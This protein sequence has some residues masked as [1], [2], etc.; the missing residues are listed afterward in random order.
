MKRSIV[1]FVSKPDFAGRRCSSNQERYVKASLTSDNSYYLPITF[2]VEQSTDIDRTVQAVHRVVLAE[3][4]LNVT[5]RAAGGHFVCAAPSSSPVACQIESGPVDA[6]GLAERIAAFVY[7]PQNILGAPTC[8]LH[9]ARLDEPE[10]RTAITIALHHAVADAISLGL[11]A[12]RVSQACAGL[13]AAAPAGRDYF[14]LCDHYGLMPG[15][16]HPADVHYWAGALRTAPDDCGQLPLFAGSGSAGGQ[17]A[18]VQHRLGADDMTATAAAAARAGVTVFQFLFAAYLLTL[19]RQTGAAAAC[20]TFQSSGRHGKPDMDGVIGEFSNALPLFAAPD[21]DHGFDD[22]AATIRAHVRAALA[23]EKLPYDEIIRQ[24]GFHPRFGINWYPGTETL[25]LD[26]RAYPARH[27][28]EWQSDYDLNLHC[29]RDG[30]GLSLEMSHPAGAARGERAALVLSQMAALLAQVARDGATPLRDIRLPGPALPPAA[31]KAS[32]PETLWDRFAGTATR[33]PDAEAISAGGR[34]ISYGELLALVEAVAAALAANGVGPRTKL[35]IL[36]DRGPELIAL[37]LAANRLGAVFAIYDP[38][39]PQ[40]R[41]EVMNE[42]FRPDFLLHADAP[43]AAARIV[44]D[45]GLQPLDAAGAAPLA[46]GVDYVLFTS[47]TTGRPKCV[48]TAAHGLLS[49]IG[50][51]IATHGFGPGSRFSLL[52]GLGHDPMLRDVFTGLLCGGTICVPPAEFRDDPRRL[53]DWLAEERVTAAHLTPQMS[54]LIAMGRR[55]RVLADLAHV[56]LGGDKLHRAEA[57]ALFE[58]APNAQASVFYGLTETPQAAAMWPVERTANWQDAPIGRG[59]NGRRVTVRRAHADAGYGEVGEITVEGSDLFLGYYDAGAG[60][61]GLADGPIRTLA[62]GDTGYF[63]PSD[64]IAIVGRKDDQVKIR[65][66]RVEPGEIAA[67]LRAQP[68]VDQAAILVEPMAGGENKLLAYVT[69]KAGAAPDQARLTD[70]CA[71]QL[72][73]HMMPHA[74]FV[75]EALPLTINGKL[76]KAR[77]PREPETAADGDVVD[78]ATETELAIVAE[79]RRTLGAR[80]VSMTSNVRDLGA[81]SLSYLNLMLALEKVVGTLPDDWDERPLRDLADGAGE[82]GRFSAVESTILMRAISIMAVVAG[83]FG[84]IAFGGATSALYFIAGH[85]FGRFQVPSV[86]RENSVRS[87]LKTIFQVALPTLAAML[88]QQFFFRKPTPITWLFLGNFVGPNVAGGFSYWFVDVLIQMMLVMALL[89]ALPAMREVTRRR[90]FET[91][92][93]FTVA[94]FAIAA[95]VEAVWDTSPLYD[96]VPTS[97]IWL[98]G[99]GWCLAQS[100]G[101]GQR[102]A[103]TALVV[104]LLAVDWM[105]G[106]EAQPLTLAAFAVIL[107]V[108]RIRMPRPISKAV[109]MTAAASLFIY[110]VHFQLRSLSAK[111]GG[112]PYSDWAA[113]AVAIIVG[114]VC[115]KLWDAVVGRVRR[116]V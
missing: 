3:P 82:Q 71:R 72:P 40:A 105:L 29:I 1:N 89:F 99:L 14:S 27:I 52:G 18:R 79:V 74:L 60:M 61:T 87:I 114:I 35:A 26:G 68:D 45:I 43:A 83:H 63:L 65:G 76:D 66:Y 86:L 10:R 23:H 73:K 108:D 28:V 41:I 115:Q 92:F 58:A 94:S 57:E 116:P 4:A 103:A 24:T 5:I 46:P 17:R 21:A 30:D 53:F 88:V 106:R 112:H 36:A 13:P 49:F 104:A 111:L 32:I 59:V 113:A 31:V 16:W 98:I 19:A 91:A 9:V 6:E 81:D 75:L 107:L 67:F 90:P 96:R 50:W 33:Q 56:F 64:E 20:A 93:L 95:L 84:L 25:T 70:A 101:T 48:A 39:Y 54:K 15:E 69:P 102:I 109:A 85:S 7:A 78:P 100:H 47:G 97:K 38:A 55:D 12:E 11:F 62:T 34:A 2:L 80:T 51:H 37:L 22:F 8:K 44:G 77:L 42:V 110:L